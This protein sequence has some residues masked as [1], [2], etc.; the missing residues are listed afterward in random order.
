[1]LIIKDNEWCECKSESNDYNLVKHFLLTVS[2][3]TDL[4]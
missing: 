3:G 1:M 4:K 2:P